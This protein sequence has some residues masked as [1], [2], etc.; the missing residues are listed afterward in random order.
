[1]DELVKLI[2]RLDVSGKQVMIETVIVEV[3]HNTMTSLGFEF[4]S[5][6][7]ALSSIGRFGVNTEATIGN[8]TDYLDYTTGLQ[9]SDDF[10]LSGFNL[11]MFVDFLKKNGNARILNQQTLWT[12][13]N[14]EANFFKGKQIP[15]V[16]GT[17][18]TNQGSGGTTSSDT[19]EFQLVWKFVSGRELHRKI[20]L[21]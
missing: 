17:T 16:T 20:T 10:F 13:D 7:T 12:K 1:M 18:T 4:S 21:V 5:D 14:D 3:E 15:F 19:Y 11:T 6:G 9:K 2:E 8:P